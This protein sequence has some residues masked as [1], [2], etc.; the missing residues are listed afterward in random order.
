ML[1]IHY[2]MA[3]QEVIAREVLLDEGLR[4][5]VEVEQAAL[6][7]FLWWSGVISVHV[8]VDQNRKDYTV[9]PLFLHL[10][11]KNF[12]LLSFYKYDI[13]LPKSDLNFFNFNFIVVEGCNTFL[14]S[15]KRTI[16][17]Y[18]T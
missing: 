3:F 1:S 2:P 6:W 7:K 9:S 14:H 12:S 8:F 5:V 13:F 15:P 10:S 4:Q 17:L 16:S 11:L 18:C